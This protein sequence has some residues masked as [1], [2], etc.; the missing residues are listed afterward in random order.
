MPPESTPRSSPQYPRWTSKQTR[1]LAALEDKMYYDRLLDVL[2]E[3]AKE[4]S[5]SNPGSVH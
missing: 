5:Q 2:L 1:M 4:E 3:I